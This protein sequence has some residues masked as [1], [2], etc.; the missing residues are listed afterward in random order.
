MNLLARSIKQAVLFF[1]ETFKFLCW[2]LPVTFFSYLTLSFFLYYLFP[3][4]P[5]EFSEKIIL[6]LANA[7]L[8]K[9]L[10]IMFFLTVVGI[11]IRQREKKIELKLLR[12]K[13]KDELIVALITS[14]FFSTFFVKSFFEIGRPE[15]FLIVFLTIIFFAFLPQFI[16]FYSFI[17]LSYFKKLIKTSTELNLDLREIINL[18]RQMLIFVK[19]STI[20]LTR[21]LVYLF[22]FLYSV[23]LLVWVVKR[24]FNF[25]ILMPTLF[26]LS[27]LVFLLFVYLIFVSAKKLTYLSLNYLRKLITYFSKKKDYLIRLL[28]L[29]WKLIKMTAIGVVTISLFV[30]TIILIV[31]FLTWQL[32]RYA[33]YQRRLRENLTIMSVDPSTTTLAQKVRLKGYNFG[34][35]VNKKDRLMSNYGK[36]FVDEWKG[37]ELIFTIPLHWKEGTVNLWIEKNKD[38]QLEG[39]LIKSNVVRL[40]VLSR[41]DFFPAEEELRNK[42]PLS[43][44]KRAVKKI[45]RTLFLQ[46]PYFQ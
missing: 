24:L 16:L 46:K 43:Y 15:P 17:D 27:V 21:I 11:F 40:K 26:V 29:I 33:D 42:D 44:L 25:K 4:F 9:L 23:L 19:K 10:M 14:F 41:W 32:N 31:S 39:K 18:L 34:W 2:I 28:Q 12:F 30:F 45:R 20:E 5:I 37:E 38:D 3:D 13:S 22:I 36:V 8:A 7:D 35:R 6:S 1:Y